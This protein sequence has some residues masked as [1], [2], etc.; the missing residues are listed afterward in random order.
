MGSWMG[1]WLRWYQ[2]WKLRRNLVSLWGAVGNLAGM[3]PWLEIEKVLG[4]VV[5]VQVGKQC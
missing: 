3:V 4:H 2:G 5:K 1:T